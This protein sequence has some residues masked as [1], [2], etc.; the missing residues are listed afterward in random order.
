MI[1]RI[2]DRAAFERL[3]QEGTRTR[4]GVLWCTYVPDPREQ[5]PRVAFAIGRAIGSA[6]TRNQL[7]RRIRSILHHTDV[8]PGI[9]LLGARPAAAARSY[10]ELQFDVEQLIQRCRSQS[11]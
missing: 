9:Y 8:P 10:S 11:G 1:W 4:A 5:P 7:R 6:V 3:A 2:R